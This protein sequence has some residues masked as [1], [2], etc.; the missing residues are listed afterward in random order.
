V[1]K[2]LILLLIVALAAGGAYYYYWVYRANGKSDAPAPLTAKV[3]RGS[4]QLAVP[5]PGRIVSNLDV[6]IKCKASGEVLSLPFDVSDTVKKDDLLVELDPV[7]EQRVV[8][9]A[10]V[11]LEAA[12]ARLRI[13]R[14]NLAV[15]ERTLLTD[16]ERAK[17][18][19][20]AAQ[21]HATDARAKAV[22]ELP[23]PIYIHCH[24]MIIC[25][26]SPYF[27]SALAGGWKEGE[28]KVVEIAMADGAAVRDLK[29]LPKLSYGGKCDTLFYCL[30]TCRGN[31]FSLPCTPRLL[32][33]PTNEA[34]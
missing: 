18:A 1:K 3:E 19:L 13:A 7:D 21:V 9:K 29:L 27:A 30:V 11:D 22:A 6:D 28:T 25:M 34:R 33:P 24:T 20:E 4:I 2:W 8:R 32:R 5:S 12:E 15:A 26:R 23:G 10:E 16:Q 14:E 31:P 17:A